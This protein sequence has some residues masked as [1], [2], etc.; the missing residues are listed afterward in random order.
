ME[1]DLLSLFLIIYLANLLNDF[2]FFVFNVIVQY[3]RMRSSRKNMDLLRK[4][5]EAAMKSGIGNDGGGKK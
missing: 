1:F 4:N 3:Y 5:L 2:T